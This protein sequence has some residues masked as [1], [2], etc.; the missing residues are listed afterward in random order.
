MFIWGWGRQDVTR[1][2]SERDALVFEYKYVHVMWLLRWAWA[3][4]HQTATLTPNGWAVL[5]MT[6]ERVRLSGAD[7]VVTLHWWWR[8]SLPG[9]FVT[10]VMAVLVSMVISAILP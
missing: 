7:Q 9:G 8:W 2:V 6:R 1:Q 10:V 4:Q 5:P 3:F